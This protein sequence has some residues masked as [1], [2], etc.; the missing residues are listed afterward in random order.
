[1]YQAKSFLAIIPARSGSSGLKDKNIKPL[2]GKPLLAHTIQ[3]AK[4]S[5]IFD[6]I[7]VSTDSQLYA[8]IATDYGADV[9]FLRPS[10]IAT[11][12]SHANEYL[13]HALTSLQALGNYFD[14]FVL[15][16]P[17]SPLRTAQ[18]IRS[19]VEVLMRE[20]QT[21]S[22]VGL[23]DAGHLPLISNTLPQDGSIYGFLPEQNNQNRQALPT[24]YTISGAFYAM[25]TQAFLRTKN[26][27]GQQ[28]KPFIMPKEHCIDVDTQLD[29]DFAQFLLERKSKNSTPL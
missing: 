24:Y 12:N 14:Y 15:L 13:V 16:L 18:D 20:P 1:M 27:Y 17:T 28:S 3:A 10:A 25:D 22:V 11:G 21:Q 23:Y 29:F 7:F 9:P 19:G 5:A 26:F 6:Y 2:A 8:D 4:E